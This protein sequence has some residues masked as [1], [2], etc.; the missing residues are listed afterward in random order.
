MQSLLTLSHNHHNAREV[1][2]LL[3]VN[4]EQITFVYNSRIKVHCIRTV[5]NNGVILLSSHV[6]FF[7][8]FPS[9]GTCSF[10]IDLVDPTVSY[11]VFTALT[12]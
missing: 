3:R 4:L 9:I 1:L 8:L 12:G 7:L 2:G 10:S 11:S 5:N 6:T